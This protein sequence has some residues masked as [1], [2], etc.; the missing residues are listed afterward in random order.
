MTAKELLERAPIERTEAEMLLAHVLG[1]QRAWLFSHGDEGLAPDDADAFM[2]HARAR[3]NGEPLAYLMGYRD[4]WSLRLIVDQHVLIPRRETEH[5]VEWALECLDSGPQKVLDLGTGSGAIALACKSERPD[6]SVTGVDQSEQALACARRNSEALGLEVCWK[7]GSWFEP[8]EAGGWDL[9]VSN[10]P[11]IAANDVHLG[12]GD[13]PAEPSGALI[14]GKTGLEMLEHIVT[15]APPYLRASG[16]LLLEHGFD[17][18]EQVRALLTNRGFSNVAM[19][20]DWS[21]QPRIS[22]GQWLN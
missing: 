18:A 19:R 9:V 2:V 15:E 13:L 8:V 16:W 22:G 20:E 12:Q 4:F 21:G 14:G 11:Y 17:Q 5:L 7:Q 6:L 10:P 3:A 1:V